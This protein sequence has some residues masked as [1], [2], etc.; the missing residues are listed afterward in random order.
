MDKHHFRDEKD[1]LGELD[2]CALDASELELLASLRVDSDD[3]DQ[4]EMALLR[5]RL[6]NDKRLQRAVDCAHDFDRHA[7][8]AMHDIPVLAGLEE[9]LLAALAPRNAGLM[10]PN[11][12]AVVLSASPRV[13]SIGGARPRRLMWGL[14][15]AASLLIAAVAA[16]ESWKPSPWSADEI[17]RLAQTWEGDL[18][19]EWSDRALP[20]GVTLPAS[21]AGFIQ[22]WQLLSIK[23]RDAIAVRLR[24]GRLL[25]TLFIIDEHVVGLPNSVPRNPQSSTGGWTVGF[26][27]EHGKLNVL[28]VQGNAEHYKQFAP[29]T[30]GALALYARRTLRGLAA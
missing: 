20:S 2:R 19:N 3:L 21:L 1:G 5:V 11:E 26:W 16:W 27:R 28:L 24:Q 10:A 29:P 9:R 22:D 6:A 17:P 4:P 25:A 14:G 23:G 12:D 8:T 18:P 30:S 7:R 15:I 13:A